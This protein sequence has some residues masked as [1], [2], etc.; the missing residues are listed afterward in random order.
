MRLLV[1]GGTWFLGKHIAE[2]ALARGWDVAT[3]NR[4]RSGKDVPG[5][6]PVHGDRTVIEDVRRLAAHGPRDAVIDTSS[7]DLPPRDVL[8][9]ASTLK[10]CA[11]RWMASASAGL[12]RKAEFQ[13]GPE[14]H[15][16]A[17][18]AINRRRRG[19]GRPARPTGRRTQPARSGRGGVGRRPGARIGG[20]ITACQIRSRVQRDGQRPTDRARIDTVG[21]CPFR[22]P[23]HRQE[24]HQ[25]HPG[26]PA[27]GRR[28][29]EDVQPGAELGE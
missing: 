7:S 16:R 5:V 13:M 3:F 22:R 23:G 14:V 6:K 12:C 1:M 8:L 25:P 4:G 19:R 21:F 11:A 24:P 26:R 17:P 9:A 15:A 29:H 28:H 27:Q 18:V 10:D 20:S 2:A